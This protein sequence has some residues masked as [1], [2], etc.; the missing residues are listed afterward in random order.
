MSAACVSWMPTANDSRWLVGALALR[1]SSIC[2]VY[3]ATY[4][5]LL[6]SLSPFRAARSIAESRL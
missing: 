3:Q 1:V 4:P 5:S 2:M 6:M